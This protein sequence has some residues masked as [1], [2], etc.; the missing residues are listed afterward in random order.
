MWVVWWVRKSSPSFVSASYVFKLVRGHAL[1]RLKE[2]F[3][4]TYVRLN[5]PEMLLQG[6]DMS[7]WFHH[8]AQCLPKPR[9]CIPKQKWTQ[10]FPDEESAINFYCRG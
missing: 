8:S 10:T 4:N 2:D 3:I 6:F 7:S 9:F 5:S 1:F